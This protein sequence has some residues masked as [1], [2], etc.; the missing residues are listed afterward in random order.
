MTSSLELAAHVNQGMGK[1]RLNHLRMAASVTT[2]ALRILL[3]VR[4]RVMRHLS[5]MSR[6][7]AKTKPGRIPGRNRI[8][9][10]CL[11]K[12]SGFIREFL[13]LFEITTLPRLRKRS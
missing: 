9:S 3:K 12:P 4:F 8:F 2:E 13:Q 6:E 11:K 1:V 5:Q 7:I 10:C